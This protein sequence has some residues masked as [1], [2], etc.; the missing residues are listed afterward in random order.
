M[1]TL[2]L[3]TEG[4]LTNFERRIELLSVKEI[5]KSFSCFLLCF[6]LIEYLTFRGPPYVV[7]SI[8]DITLSAIDSSKRLYRFDLNS[9]SRFNKFLIFEIN[10]ERNFKDSSESTE[11][12]YNVQGHSYKGNVAV[13]DDHYVSQPLQLKFLPQSNITEKIRLYS[14]PTINFDRFS[15]VTYLE[16]LDKKPL[17]MHF[18]FFTADSA[19]TILSFIVR[20]VLFF[21]GFVVF[22][23][24]ASRHMKLSHSSVSNQFIY[25][26]LVAELLATNPLI[27]LDCFVDTTAFS[28]TDAFCS[29]LFF[30]LSCYCSFVHL[31]YKDRKNETPSKAVLI[32]I[33]IPFLVVFGLMFANSFYSVIKISTDPII[34]K[35]GAWHGLFYTQFVLILLFVPVTL[36]YGLCPL[37]KANS[38]QKVHVVIAVTFAIIVLFQQ[39]H[40]P[41]EQFIGSCYAMQIYSTASAA[42]FTLFFAY[43]NWPVEPS[44]DVEDPDTIVVNDADES[45]IDEEK[46]KDEGNSL[47]DN[48][49]PLES[50]Q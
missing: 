39:L 32:S 19:F 46:M 35:T 11:I 7:P 20:I 42:V 47:I 22:L 21:I 34:A 9:F 15:L 16:F 36:F 30:V 31:I 1:E 40:V 24:F 37:H 4:S 48:A 5:M 41:H 17:T 2:S 45:L 13:N 26:L 38:D 29:Q 18:S 27:I 10:F 25:I 14:I 12:L 28:L 6:I 33:A 23:R 43:F 49:Q 3:V 8:E 50:L 44:K